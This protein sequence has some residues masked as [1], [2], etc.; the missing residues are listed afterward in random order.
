MSTPFY[1]YIVVGAGSS[2]AT[3]ATRLAERQQGRVLLLEA[4]GPRDQDFWVQVPLG[5]A[6]I[7]TDPKYVWQFQTTPQNQLAGQQIYWPRGR[8]PGGSSSVNGMIYV[9]GE[10]AEFDHWAALGNTGWDYASLLPYFKRLENA[11][12]GDPGQRGHDGPISVSQVSKVHPNPLSDAFLKACV[13]AGIPM[14]PDYN[15]GGSYEGVNYLQLST[16]AGRRCS[17]AAGYLHGRP[18]SN[19]EIATGAV[20]ARLIFDGTRVAGVEYLQD[21]KARQAMA[22]AEVIVCAG[23]IKSPQLLELSGI[24]DGE[25]LRALGI[26]VRRH[27]PGVGENLVD[28]LQSRITFECTRPITLNEIVRSPMRQAAMGAGYL[29]RRRGFMATPSATVHALARTDPREARP[30]VK[31]QLHHLTGAD[32]YAGKGFGLDPFPGFA[33]GFFQ[34]RPQSRGQ[35][36]VRTP[37]PADDPVIE[38]RYLDTEEDREAMLAALRLSRKV[39]AQASMSGF[40]KRETRPGPDVRDDDG[41]LEY[42]KKSG[43]TSWHP[44]GTCKMGCDDMAVVD[45]QLRVKGIAG[46]RVADSSVM[47]TM[48]SSNTNAASIMIGEKAAD[49][50]LERH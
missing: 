46:L 47:P 48:C 32:R 12:F 1:D 40:V 19:L 13:D 15:A 14:T 37:D 27:L 20:A 25:R 4:G 5:V 50:V 8:M 2:G 36:H 45:A 26:E 42:I 3:L 31:I 44:V 24:G 43:Q 17:T 39:I 33:V 41:L 30:R 16:R 23:P 34:L 18:Q 28:H 7:L 6:K 10:P 38:P 11:A 49:L 29:L 22:Q 35:L 21:G 9:R